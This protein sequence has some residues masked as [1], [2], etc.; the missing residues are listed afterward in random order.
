VVDNWQDDI[1]KHD[2]SDAEKEDAA[3]FI[4]RVKIAQI[5]TLVQSLTRIGP[6]RSNISVAKDQDD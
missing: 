4:R 5:Q 1:E 2:L 6:L 3:E